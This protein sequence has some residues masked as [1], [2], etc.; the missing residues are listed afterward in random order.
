MRD[1]ILLLLV[2]FGVGWLSSHRWSIESKVPEDPEL[3]YE[4][5]ATQTFLDRCGAPGKNRKPV[6]ISMVYGEE[7][8]AWIEQAADRFSRLCPNIQVQLTPMSNNGAVEAILEGKIRPTLWAPAD[9]LFL[10]YL[11]H[12]WQQRFKE[13]PFDPRSHASLVVSPLVWVAWESRYRVIQQILRG[14]RSKDDGTWVQI[15]C[16]NIPK[17]ETPA[18]IALRDR[19]AGQL[20]SDDLIAGKWRDW[21]QEELESPGATDPTR[22]PNLAQ[23]KQTSAGATKPLLAPSYVPTLDQVTGWGRVKF[24]HSDPTH[25]G[26]GLETIYLMA[27]EFLVPPADR[28]RDQIPLDEREQAQILK[29]RVENPK[30][31]DALRS[32]LQRC[33]AGIREFPA[34]TTAL[35]TDMVNLGPQRSDVVVTFEHL[36]FP[37]LREF[38]KNGIQGEGLHVFYPQPTVW[39][40][41]PVV[42][43][44]PDAPGRAAER[45]PAAKWVAFLLGTDMQQRAID[46]GFRPANPAVSLRAYKSES[47]PFLGAPIFGIRPDVPKKETARPDGKTLS[48]LVQTWGEATG[49]R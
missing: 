15:P 7:K 23:R 28:M 10:G 3:A 31:L 41:H 4:E 35:L 20:S 16:A 44:T 22:S 14:G 12:R 32:W 8:R 27:L 33:E 21:Y 1:V 25:T 40:N 49:R 34:T 26:S 5:V 39:N 2:L 43:M 45:G 13:Q 42:L 36:T 30:E 19:L 6:L 37:I 24:I 29:N 18:Q 46:H 11:E 17:L 47:N 9:D 48:T 38:G